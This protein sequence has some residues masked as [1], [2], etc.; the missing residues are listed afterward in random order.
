MRSNFHPFPAGPGTSVDKNPTI[1]ELMITVART[2]NW[3]DVRRTPGSTVGGGASEPGM[4]LMI[5]TSS[6]L[7][8]RPTWYVHIV[9]KGYFSTSFDYMVPS[10]SM[11]ST[12]DVLNNLRSHQV[13]WYLC[14]TTV[15]YP[16]Y[17][18]HQRSSP[19]QPSFHYH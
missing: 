15:Y 16:R 10:K 6:N 18:L 9:T 1:S 19:N 12:V 5:R 2:L 7:S 14:P 11:M 8:M 3:L 13:T 4:V 17:C